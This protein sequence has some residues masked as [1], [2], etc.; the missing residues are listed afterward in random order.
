MSNIVRITAIQ[1]GPASEN[2][3]ENVRRL[4]SLADAAGKAKP[5][6][7]MFPELCTTPYWCN[8]PYFTAHF[9][10]AEPIPGPT[11]AL[12]SQKARELGTHIVL[13]VYEK[14]STEGEYYNSAVLIGPDGEIVRG[15]L[16][17]GPEV[18][19]YRKISPSMGIEGNDANLE[20]HYIRS[21]WGYCV[22]ETRFCRVGILICRDRLLTEAWR[23]L[24]L[25][26][27]RIV[28]V[29][30]AS[31]GETRAESFIR[32]MRTSAQENQLVAVGCNH[33]GVEGRND[34]FGSSCIVGAGGE[35][36]AFGPPSEEAMISAELDLDDII[37]LRARSSLYRVRRPELYGIITEL[38]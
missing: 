3:D 36:I 38:R 14:G 24:G 6:F 18:H 1:T 21:G 27:A 10:W 4:L 12:F 7:I 2:K 22:F 32:T 13:S 31:W 33:A 23:V 20:I 26:D 17:N 19:C 37:E 25:Q 34:F 8:R 30:V 5:D 29:P 16:P 35:V 9:A 28:F 11:T 15:K